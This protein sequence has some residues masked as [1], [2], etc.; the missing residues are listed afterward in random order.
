MI[1]PGKMNWQRYVQFIILA[2]VFLT[3]GWGA[4]AGEPERRMRVGG[5]VILYRLNEEENALK[6]ASALQTVVPRMEQF[7]GISVPAG[8]RIVIVSD[9]RMFYQRVGRVLP[10]W[11]G[12]VFIPSRRMILVK[13]PRWKGT[14]FDMHKS[15]VHELSHA[16]FATK[17]RDG[18]LPLWFNEGLAELISEGGISMEAG[19][20][21]AKA[22]WFKQLIPLA[23]VDSL[24]RFSAGRARLAYIQ[25]LSAV[26]FLREKLPREAQWEAFLRSVERKGLDAA[27][28]EWLNWDRID[29]EIKWYKWLRHKYRWFI[30]LNFDYFIWLFLVLMFL[31]AFVRRYYQNRKRLRRWEQEELWQFGNHGHTVNDLR[32]DDQR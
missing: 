14:L 13:S 8:L 17:F 15:L 24:F 30:L 27:L 32:E 9:E 1:S 31:L 25:S 16:F 7:Y 4:G 29:F 18:V 5:L 10:Q 26:I 2:T 28:K 6:V 3:P 12:A 19:I 11:V 20:E 23:D 21:L 22:I